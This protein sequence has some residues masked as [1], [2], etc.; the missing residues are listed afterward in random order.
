VNPDS[1]EICAAAAAWTV[2][3]LALRGA[4]PVAQRALRWWALP[5]AVMVLARADGVVWLAIV[6]AGLAVAAYRRGVHLDPRRSALRQTLMVTVAAAAVSLGWTVYS[7]QLKVGPPPGWTPRADSLGV[8]LGRALGQLPLWWQQ[9]VAGFGWRDTY[10]PGAVGLV[11]LAALLGLGWLARPDRRVAVAAAG[12]VVAALVISLGAQAHGYD[13]LGN[14]WQGRYVLPALIGVPV[15]VS[16]EPRFS[17]PRDRV[18]AKWTSVGVASAVLG[19]HVA[20]LLV[21]LHRCMNGLGHDFVWNAPWAPPLD[22]RLLVALDVVGMLGLGAVALLVATGSFGPRRI[23]RH[24][25]AA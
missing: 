4:G 6:V 22:A 15:L 23:G 10:L 24:H 21:W 8:R 12:L 5:A 13:L 25:A 3:L 14:W 17:R 1:G 19:L 18:G 11:L 20:G 7:G 16:L 2:G 9:A